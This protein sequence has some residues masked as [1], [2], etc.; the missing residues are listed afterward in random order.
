MISFIK[1]ERQLRAKKYNKTKLRN[2]N[3]HLW[4]CRMFREDSGA[5]RS[6]LIAPTGMRVL[7]CACRKKGETMISL[8]HACNSGNSEEN[9]GL[10]ISPETKH[11]PAADELNIAEMLE[12]CESVD[13]ERRE[14]LSGWLLHC[15]Q[16]HSMN[17]FERPPET[18]K[19]SISG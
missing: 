3:P 19:N 18:V 7:L 9:A 10:N 17:S 11:V 5:V 8:K 6:R 13:N 2:W 15:T 16:P 4:G 14:I 12:Q 1:A